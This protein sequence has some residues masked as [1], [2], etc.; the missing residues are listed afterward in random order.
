MQKLLIIVILVVVVAAGAWYIIPHNNNKTEFSPDVSMKMDTS[1][2][3]KEAKD[4]HLAKRYLDGI[5]KGVVIL[6]DTD[7]SAREEIQF[8]EKKI[9][10]YAKSNQQKKLNTDDVKTLASQTVSLFRLLK[11]ASSRQDS[12][13]EP[14]TPVSSFNTMTLIMSME[15]SFK[16]KLNFTFSEFMGAQ[17]GKLLQ[18]L[19]KNHSN[20]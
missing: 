20:Q 1:E 18:G 12:G 15:A 2:I 7:A 6:D 3:E 17:D 14:Y 8:W 13:L 16:D 5:P 9:V 19:V 10:N 11:E 4:S